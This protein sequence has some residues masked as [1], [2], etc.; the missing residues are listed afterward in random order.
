MPKYEKFENILKIINRLDKSIY[1]VTIIDL[2]A[3]L[4]VN[5]KSVYRYVNTINNA[6]IPID[7]VIDESGKPTG[8]IRFFNDFN[9]KKMKVSKEEITLLIILHEFTKKIK[10]NF[11]DS[12]QSI[13]NKVI[14]DSGKDYYYVKIPNGLTINND[15][16]FIKDIEKAIKENK[17]MRI[18]YKKISNGEEYTYKIIP[19]KIIFY[20]GFWYLPGITEKNKYLIKYRIDNITSVEILEENI[21]SNVN[22]KAILDN[23]MNIFFTKER[24]KTVKLK[25]DKK[26]MSYFKQKTIFPC[27][28]IIEETEEGIIIE[29]VIGNFIELFRLIC[30]W[31]PHI[32][33]IEPDEFKE[34][35]KKKI[36]EYYEIL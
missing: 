6:G 9:M 24:D 4:G 35:F 23:S 18:K 20:D 22:I 33:I 34:E 26:A 19:L 5:K 36:K 2:A 29:S 13:L 1:P 8:K 30:Q 15:S 3:E 28:K 7:Q 10:N 16:P 31:I 25:V 12:F 27:Q 11:N 32:F 17:K 21:D 14:S